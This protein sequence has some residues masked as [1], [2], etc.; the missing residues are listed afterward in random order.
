MPTKPKPTTFRKKIIQPG[1][2]YVPKK[3]GGTT[4]LKV[5]RKRS[6]GWAV[7]LKRM[8]DNGLQ[9][10]APWQH[11]SSEPTPFS[12]NGKKAIPSKN[13]AGYWRKFWTEK[14]GSL[15]GE[16]EVDNPEDA[17][18]VGTNVT[19]V[20]PYIK[21]TWT[22]GANNS[23]E[24][25]FTHVALVTHPVIPGQDNFSQV[26]SES[27]QPAI[28]LSLSMLDPE[29]ALSVQVEPDAAELFESILQGLRG[30]GVVLPEDT[31]DENFLDRLR[32]AL[33]QKQTD[34]QEAKKAGSLTVPPPGSQEQ[35]A[36]LVMSA[37][38]I[39][40]S[41]ISA[42]DSKE[43]I[44]SKIASALGLKKSSEP[45]G[46]K[47]ISITPTGTISM[48]Q[49]II[50]ET[51]GDQNHPAMIALRKQAVNGYKDRIRTLYGQGK[52]TADYA[53]KELNPILDDLALSFDGEG[54]QEPTVID[55]ILS[56]LESL[57]NL[58]AVQGSPINRI[59]KTEMVLGQKQGTALSNAI[60]EELPPEF[61]VGK[62]VVDD[63]RADEII[64]TQFKN[65]GINR[66][67]LNGV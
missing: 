26:D 52:I 34:V 13:N 65:S 33:L 43:T 27:S 22:D 18:K 63:E 37:P 32:S 15:Y 55:Q 54:N 14:D 11:D 49:A 38:D 6:E 35:P 8:L 12:Q 47:T 41:L 39:Q 62:D 17:K 42:K 40:T 67:S 10:P 3:G 50:S 53:N 56:P 9:I 44:L 60:E 20:S 59:K 4:E 28:A 19:E 46:E 51:A 57:P 61:T 24:D 25:V 21:P 31:T 2:Y 36:P 23:Y 66:D 29:F 1:T 58:V 64:K 48:S 45:S 30:I 16:L 5:D 7:T